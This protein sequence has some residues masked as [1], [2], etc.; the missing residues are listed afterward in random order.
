[1]STNMHTFP[2][3]FA[4]TISGSLGVPDSQ[5]TYSAIMLEL[6]RAVSAI[7]GDEISWIVVAAFREGEVHW[8]SKGYSH[9]LAIHPNNDLPHI[10]YDVLSDDLENNS[11]DGAPK[12]APST[13]SIANARSALDIFIRTAGFAEIDP[14]KCHIKLSD[15]FIANNVQDDANRSECPVSVVINIGNQSYFDFLDTQ[16]NSRCALLI[17]IN[18]GV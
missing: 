3:N 5:R 13:E 9:A 4:E 2:Q 15:D 14:H 17:E 16:G 12:K 6:A 8:I 7:C 18:H 10:L 1:M 11:N